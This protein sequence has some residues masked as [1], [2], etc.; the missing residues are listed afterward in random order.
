MP[1]LLLVAKTSGAQ[2]L[3]GAPLLL[4]MH[5]KQTTTLTMLPGDEHTQVWLAEAGMSAHT[6]VSANHLLAAV[7]KTRCAEAGALTL[8]TKCLCQLAGIGQV[9]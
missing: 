9:T 3:G 2:T 5:A 7:R 8:Q 1:K 6:A 4:S